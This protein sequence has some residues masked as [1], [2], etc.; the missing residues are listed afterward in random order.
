MSE[1]TIKE[2]KERLENCIDLYVDFFCQKQELFFDYWVA[3]DKGGIAVI[4]DRCSKPL[5]TEWFFYI[6]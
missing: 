1:V 5:L 6:Q 3:D 4:G 2:V